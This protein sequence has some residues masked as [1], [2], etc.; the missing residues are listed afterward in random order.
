MQAKPSVALVSLGCPKNLVDSEYICEKFLG[1]GY[2][3]VEDAAAAEI[4][5]VNTCGFLTSAVEESIETILAFV[6]DGKRVICT[7]CMVSRYEERL[8][9]ELPEVELF[10]GPGTYE[11]IVTDFESHTD[12]LIP[13][14][15]NVVGRS[16]ISTAASAYV[17]I[18]EGCSNHCSFCMIPS[19]RGE[20][21]SKPRDQIIDECRNLL[22]EGV[23]EIILIGQ[24]LGSYGKDLGH[25]NALPAL[26]SEIADLSGLVWLRVM[27]IHPESMTDEMLDTIANHP[28]ICS[29][30]DMPVQHVADSVLKQMGRRGGADFVRGRVAAI[31]QRGIWLRTTVMVGHPGEDAAAFEQ[32]ADFVAE[33]HFDHL[34]AF[35]FSPEDGTRS[36]ELAQDISEELKQQRLE[37]IMAIQ[38]EVSRQKMQSLVGQRI[39]VLVEGYHPETELLLRG[40][41]EFQA[42]EVDGCCIINEGG[43]DSGEFCELEILEAMEYDLVGRIV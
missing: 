25:E 19:L 9:E 22:A 5:I 16:V 10:S 12:R 24:D 17:K 42:P 11:T 29:Y 26:M 32:L 13:R 38:Q 33:G 2:P 4:V 30:V 37:R 23:R 21:L 1:G 15:D 20:L 18:S 34:G 43:A 8:R 41:C 36:A 35:A 28:K 31:K 27:Y 40:R 6:E 39:K 3:I 14:F 7:G